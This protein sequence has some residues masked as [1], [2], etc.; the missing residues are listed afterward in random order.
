LSCQSLN[1]R[2]VV[3]T[4]GIRWTEEHGLQQQRW[5]HFS[6]DQ[7]HHLLSILSRLSPDWCVGVSAL[8]LCLE[9]CT[10]LADTTLQL[11]PWDAGA[12][13][14]GADSSESRKSDPA[15]ALQPIRRV[16]DFLFRGG[17]PPEPLALL[18]LQRFDPQPGDDVA[19][20]RHGAVR[21]HGATA[22][23]YRA[24][25]PGGRP[26]TSCVMGPWSRWS[27]CSASCG[28]G[29][30]SR[31]RAAVV[32]TDSCTESLQIASE[33]CEVGDCA[34]DCELGDWSGWTACSDG[35]LPCS[36]DHRSCA[37][38]RRRFFRH[39]GAEEFCKHAVQ[40]EQPCSPSSSGI[41]AAF[42]V[43]AMSRCFAAADV[44]PCKGN[45]FRWHYDE[46]AGSCRT[47]LYGG[48]RGNAN[49]Y[50]TP[51]DCIHACG[52][53]ADRKAKRN[54]VLGTTTTAKMPATAVSAIPKSDSRNSTDPDVDCVMSPWS[55]W[56]SC[57]VTCGR[58]GVRMRRRIVERPARGGGRKCPRRRLRRRRCSPLPA[59]T[60]ATRCQYTEWSAWSPCAR[61]CG[62]D[63]VQER[64]QRA[65]GSLSSRLRC[66]VRLQRRM[67]ALPPCSTS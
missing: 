57:S 43:E 25:E 63:A 61:S 47:F 29:T 20:C 27:A 11:F 50:T 7:R 22:A 56:S 36:A 62:D 44:G 1:V 40:Q 28:T 48:C 5:A 60:H 21:D 16:A 53:Y 8:D 32:V 18:R 30:R 66:P 14:G 33:P 35:S 26:R 6:V 54:G 42:D 55:K 64:I 67:C 15:A 59:C 45:F 19:E 41:D 38:H 13:S 4:P 3:K 17:R 52:Q 58:N 31:S 9:N 65:Q 49:R 12:G 51:E 23:D 24:S 10:W 39:P 37:R 2:T 46:V 34:R